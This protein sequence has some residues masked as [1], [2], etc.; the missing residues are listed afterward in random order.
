MKPLV[1]T[2]VGTGILYAGM[3]DAKVHD[4]WIFDN[5]RDGVMLLAVP[6][7][8][9]KGGGAEGDVFPGVSCPGAP[10]EQAVHL[11]RQPLLQQQDGPGAAGLQV[12][13]ARSTSS[14]LSTQPQRAGQ[15]AQ[16]QRLLVGRVLRQHQELLVRQHRAGRQAGQRDRPRRRGADRRAAPGT[17]ARLQRR[18]KPG[19]ER[20]ARATSP[21]PSTWSTARRARTRTPARSTATGGPRRPSRVARPPAAGTREYAT[22]AT[23]VRALPRGRAAARSASPR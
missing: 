12:P 22:A 4:N 1:T 11:L 23:A 14:A 21:R 3:N 18:V 13:R 16:R 2:P 7:A 9:V 10:A 19:R 20:R 5:W 8:L 6:D 17:A 15:D